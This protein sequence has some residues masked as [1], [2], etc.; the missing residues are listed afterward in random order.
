M[1]SV[2][3]RC[4]LLQI[5]C[6]HLCRLHVCVCALCVCV[7]VVARVC[8]SDECWR[9][10]VLICFVCLFLPRTHSFSF[11]LIEKRSGDLHGARRTAEWR[12]LRAFPRVGGYGKGT[13]EGPGHNA[14]PVSF[15]FPPPAQQ[16]HALHNRHARRAHVL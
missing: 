6:G 7:C 10:G 15:F 9:I 1:K 11:F 3:S 8:V 4:C 5:L 2:R 12:L 13:E 14:A 16:I